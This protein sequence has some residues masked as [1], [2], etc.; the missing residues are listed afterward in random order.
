MRHAQVFG[1]HQQHDAHEFLQ[2]LLEQMDDET[3]RNRDKDGFPPTPAPTQDQPIN[4]LSDIANA[5]WDEYSS[6]HSSIIDEHF[7]FIRATNRRCPECNDQTWDWASEAY[8]T[9]P[10]GPR[11][12]SL[13]KALDDMTSDKMPFTC[14]KCKRQAAQRH[15]TH[16]YRLPSTLCFTLQRH[17][18]NLA[19]R[20][21]FELD[22]FDMS[23]WGTAPPGASNMYE[24]FAIIKHVG[25]DMTAGHY[26][27]FV[28]A[29]GSS[30][31]NSWIL[32]NDSAKPKVLYTKDIL[33]GQESIF[34]KAYILLYRRKDAARAGL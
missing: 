14:D 22:N 27:C 8:L 7:R 24:C 21:V 32:F 1:T 31:P 19:R 12:D 11:V 28:R 6:L 15:L 2:F 3:N 33:N 5:W 10:L 30:S 17:D 4:Q 23:R 13:P 9:C 16:Y 25:S 34:E 29:P 20:I 18:S 26:T